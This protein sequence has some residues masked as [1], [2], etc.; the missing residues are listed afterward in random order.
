MPHVTIAGDE[1]VIRWGYHVAVAVRG[2]TLRREAGVL[3]LTGR[4]AQI[5][6]FRASQRPL[7]FVALRQGASWR[8]PITTELQIANDTLSAC[9]GSQE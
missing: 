1:A 9:L 3:T 6:T 7:V 4:I 2:W 5:D 8:W